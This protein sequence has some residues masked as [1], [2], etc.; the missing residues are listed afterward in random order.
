MPRYLFLICLLFLSFNLRAQTWEFG[1]T[2]GAAGYMGDLNP[3]NPLKPSGISFGAFAQRNFDGYWSAKLQYTFG[4]IAADDKNSSDPQFQTRNLSFNTK[5]NEVALI[6]EFNFFRYIPEVGQ[7]RFTPFIY[8]GV[9]VVGYTPT[10]NYQGHTYDLRSLMTEGQSKPYPGSALTMPYGAGIKY[11]FA[12]KW[13]FTADIGYRHPRTDY[14]DDVS[15]NY[16]P[17]NKFIDP[18]AQALSDRSGENTGVYI[19][20]AGTQRGDLRP[21]D[22]YWF[23][24][25]SISFTIIS[26]KCYY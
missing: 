11:D 26:S 12:G 18:V 2:L 23:I 14:L 15:G 24:G 1:G 25:L 6:G 20:A 10:A 21:H 7:N 13:N 3:N 9:G 22:T 16:A 19:G 5:L 4:E 17:K 8:A